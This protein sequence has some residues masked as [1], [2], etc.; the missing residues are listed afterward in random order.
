MFISRFLMEERDTKYIIA[1]FFYVVTL[2]LH[3][4]N[5]VSMLTDMEVRNGLSFFI[6]INFI[7][8]KKRKINTLSIEMVIS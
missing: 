1:H 7:F 6:N 2:F 5:V 8:S 4:F 3:F